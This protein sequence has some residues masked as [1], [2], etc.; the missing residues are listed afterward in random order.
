MSWLI[1]LLVTAVFIDFWREIVALF[2]LLI[3][4]IGD[5]PVLGLIV[6]IAVYILLRFITRNLNESE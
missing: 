4:C 3:L 6:S 2:I 1:G 5:A